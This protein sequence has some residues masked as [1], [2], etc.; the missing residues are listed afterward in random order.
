MSLIVVIIIY[1]SMKNAIM[2][3]FTS[4]TSV[5]LFVIQNARIAG[6]VYVMNANLD[7]F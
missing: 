5:N 7:S 3:I 1:K 6:M 2:M 4:V